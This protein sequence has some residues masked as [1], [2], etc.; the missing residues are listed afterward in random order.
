[1]AR[2]EAEPRVDLTTDAPICQVNMDH[3]RVDAD[4]PDDDWQDICDS[5][6]RRA[7]VMRYLA[8]LGH[9]PTLDELWTLMRIPPVLAHDCVY[10]VSM[11]PRTGHYLT[12]V[13]ATDELIEA[14]AAAATARANPEDKRRTTGGATRQ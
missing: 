1:M 8:N 11:V 4:K 12:Q 5:R 6:T 13:Q 10:T 3:W 9:P 14:A 7:I 2:S